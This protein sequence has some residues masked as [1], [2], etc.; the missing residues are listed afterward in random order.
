VDQLV[1]QYMARICGLGYLGD[2]NHI[3]TALESVMKYNFIQDFSRQFNNMR[4]FV[5]GNERGLLMASWPHGRLKIPFPYF[6]E[7]MTGFEYCAATGMIYEGMTDEALT[8]IKAIRDRH[9]G[10]KRNPFSEAEC[11]HHYARSMASWAPVIALSGFHYS[12]VDRS[13]GFTDR[14]GSYFWSNGSAWGNCKVDESGNA[15][16]NVIRGEIFLDSFSLGR[17]TKKL[18]NRKID[19][20]QTEIIRF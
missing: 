1:G 17:R 13:M 7:V 6:G 2:S 11:G 18:R 14:P 5:M 10:A 3:H 15:E 12:G 20:G 19:A 16:L 9:D 8:C 4:S